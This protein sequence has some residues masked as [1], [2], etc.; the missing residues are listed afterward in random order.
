MT[1]L[2]SGYDLSS[3]SF[4]R[5][6]LARVLA[7]QGDFAGALATYGQVLA[8][9]RATAAR[10]PRMT[11]GIA[12]T[13]ESM[14]EVH[15]RIG[16]MDQARA[17]FYPNV[18]LTALIGSL[19]PNPFV[20]GPSSVTTGVSDAP[21]SATGREIGPSFFSIGGPTFLP[22]RR[23][24]SQAVTQTARSCAATALASFASYVPASAF[25]AASLAIAA[26]A[27]PAV[28]SRFA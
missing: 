2:T 12:V 28:P 22:T 6:G 23:K 10:D 27:A 25:A 11:S 20:S 19:A 4:A 3:A 24:S 16:N 7:A 5:G 21:F 8:D 13:L 18:N 17:A 26:T 1:L 15:F 9:A 14:G